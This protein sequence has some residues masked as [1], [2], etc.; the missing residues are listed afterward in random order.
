MDVHAGV[1]CLMKKRISLTWRGEVYSFLPQFDLYVQIEEKCTFN[2]IADA[3]RQAGLGAPADLPMSHVAW[4]LFCCLK[5][6]GADV[7]TPAEVHQALFDGGAEGS[8]SLPDYG[9][10]LGELVMA[11]YNASPEGPPKKAPGADSSPPQT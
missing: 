1:G 8:A 9:H 7:R 2:R 6:A 4:V 11:Y 5:H 3:M 10:A